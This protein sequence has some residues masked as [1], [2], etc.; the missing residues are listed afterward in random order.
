MIR[1]LDLKLK[2]D[3]VARL[4]LTKTAVRSHPA[5][6]V[7]SSP[8]FSADIQN[9]ALYN[10]I[11]KPHDPV[12]INPSVSTESVDIVQLAPLT[13][14]E[15]IQAREKALKYR[16]LQRLERKERNHRLAE[17]ACQ[18]VSKIFIDPA[19]FLPFI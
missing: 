9:M 10:E 3:G 17:E 7:M 5:Y 6:F 4:D 18:V 16:A 19:N 2:G 1:N 11:L 12:S 14:K 15:Q 13:A 8:H